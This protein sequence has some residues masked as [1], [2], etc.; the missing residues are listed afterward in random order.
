M[1]PRRWVFGGWVGDTGGG[2]AN[3]QGR[4]HVL[5][6]GWETLEGVGHIEFKGG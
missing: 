1:G 5:E 3:Y 4:W 6:K 2:V